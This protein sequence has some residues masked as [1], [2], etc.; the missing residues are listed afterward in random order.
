MSPHQ[1]RSKQQSNMLK[2]DAALKVELIWC[3]T[4]DIHSDQAK[5]SWIHSLQC[6]MIVKYQMNFPVSN[7]PVFGCA[8]LTSNNC[9]QAL[10]MNWTILCMSSMSHSIR[11][12]KDKWSHIFDFWVQIPIQYAQRT[13]IQ[14]FCE[15]MLLQIFWTYSKLRWMVCEEKML[16]ASTDQPNVVESFLHFLN[17][18]RKNAK[19]SGFI[20]VGT[21]GL[22]VINGCLQVGAK[23]TT[24][25]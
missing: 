5:I 25:S 13:I 3:Y 20:Y 2:K 15:R 21:G 10:Q 18:E 14:F 22:H 4:V 11:Y 8:L 17:E 6:F 12:S 9:C 16:Q 1:K 24:N 7:F 19:L 23:A